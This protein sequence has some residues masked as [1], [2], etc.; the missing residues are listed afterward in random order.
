MLAYLID[1][2]RSY[3]RIPL[4]ASPD[5]GHFNIDLDNSILTHTL[6]RSLFPLSQASMRVIR[7]ALSTSTKL[8]LDGAGETERA[9][10][11]FRVGPR[12]WTGPWSIIGSSGSIDRG[13][14]VGR[15]FSFLLREV[16]GGDD[17][18]GIKGGVLREGNLDGYISFSRVV[19]SLYIQS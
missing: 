5:L 1:H 8:F 15:V 2:D 11:R 4:S 19:R 3:H 18:S 9:P 13:I 12:V 14:R 7:L 16:R 10:E 17:C 6:A